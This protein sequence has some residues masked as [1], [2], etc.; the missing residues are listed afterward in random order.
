MLRRDSTITSASLRVKPS[1]PEQ[2]ACTGA[3]ASQA[4][5]SIAG[6][7]RT[8]PVDARVIAAKLTGSRYWPEDELNRL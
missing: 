5:V 4:A 7:T 3:P 6:G 8:I 1:G 2:G